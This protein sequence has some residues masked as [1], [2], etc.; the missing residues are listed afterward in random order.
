MNSIDRTVLP[1]DEARLLG[2]PGARTDFNLMPVAP[3][4]GAP[5]I[6]IV[7]IDDMGF[8][9]TS[10]FG[11]PCRTP[12]AEKL[13]QS[14]LKYTRFHT[15]ALCSPTRQ[16]LLTGRNHH[17][18][19]M[20]SVIELATGSRGYSSVRPA[21]AAPLAEILRLNGYNTAAFGK[22]HQ[23]PAWEVSAAGPFDRWPTGEG[24]EHF[25]GFM[26]AEMD[27]W[28]PLLYDGTTPI[29]VPDDP[30]YHLSEDMVAKSIDWVQQQRVLAPE[31]PFFLYLPFG[32]THGPHH[33]PQPWIDKYRGRFDLGW[34]VERE[35]IVAAQR[36]L[37]VVP[38]D[39]ELTKR[40]RELPAWNELSS[41]EKRV[42]ARLMETYAG[43]AEHTDAQVGRV[44]E[45]L[46]NLG[47]LDNTLF[48][49][50][51]GDNGASPDGGIH[52]STSEILALNG[53]SNTVEEA[54]A[55]LDQL[56]GPSTYPIYPAGW[57]HAMDTPYQWTKHV[58]SHWG[59]TRV[60]MVVHWPDG[61]KARGEVRNQWHHV[62]DVVPTIL[63][64]AKLPLP[65]LVN[66]VV[67]QRTDGVSMRY[68]FTDPAAPERHRTQYFEMHGNRGI[69]RDGWTAVTK[70]ETPWARSA[71]PPAL[72]DDVWELYAP[73]DWSQAHDLASDKPGKLKE[74]QELF[75][76]EAAVN[77]VLPID[78]RLR[79]RFYPETA[80]RPS[81]LTGRTEMTLWPGMRRV[82]VSAFL[83]VAN[84]SH[85]VEVWLSVGSDSVDGALISNGSRFAGWTLYCVE[86][87]CA[88]TYNWFGRERY[89]IT[90]A[91]ALSPG[92]HTVRFEFEVDE[93]TT[94]GRGG[95]ARL[96]IDGKLAGK[97]RIKR[98][99]PF[100]AGITSC[101]GVGCD[102]GSP[103]IQDYPTP[104][105]EFQGGV[106]H[107]VHISKD[108]GDT[109]VMSDQVIDKISL[110]HQ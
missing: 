30:N 67:Q 79:P 61:M 60:G 43:F 9:A 49:Y 15:T 57:A 69:Y 90:S 53:I 64:A 42:A 106:I 52:G 37:G 54:A 10:A 5:N 36:R 55:E 3:P 2:R 76:Q 81:L 71:T 47:A 99:I 102:L 24:F 84:V 4:E 105:G 68:S 103:V 8:G 59:G 72:D 104:H 108:A 94:F 29:D 17:A 66:G 14:G 22:W 93:G 83:D 75:L 23:T 27:Q 33:V 70:H 34:D 65:K 85:Q 35:Q 12:V 50:I 95:S 73:N 89:D 100:S 44:V 7:L 96:L 58:A 32:A 31:R 97:G 87:H 107:R 28:A 39:C 13:A 88:Y 74:L 56:G 98:T 20:G 82:P 86:G 91:I 77:H 26:G 41:D 78:D 11:G 80:G 21:S 1:I 40:H 92:H 48:F 16:A 25:Y 18:V 19:N 6:V 101:A 46:T 63:E 109:L 51:L 62:I 110:A 38:A 45:T